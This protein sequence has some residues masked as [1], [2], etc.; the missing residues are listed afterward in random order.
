MLK[1]YKTSDV[2]YISVICYTY[3]SPIYKDISYQGYIHVKVLY[4]FDSLK[5]S[6]NYMYLL[7]Y[8]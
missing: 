5:Q 2:L 7:F 8:H 1:L 6:H 4:R 3:L